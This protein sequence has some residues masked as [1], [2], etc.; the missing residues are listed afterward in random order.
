MFSK[1]KIKTKTATNE[2]KAET[3]ALDNG[4]GVLGTFVVILFVERIRGAFCDDALYKLTFTLHLYLHSRRLVLVVIRFRLSQ[5]VHGLELDWIGGLNR[6]TV[7]R[8]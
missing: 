6:L 5:S 1:I 8:Y 7:Y 2:T 3:K 4:R